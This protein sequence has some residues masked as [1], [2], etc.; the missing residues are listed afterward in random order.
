MKKLFL[1]S[2]SAMAFAATPALAQ[3]APAAP[4]SPSAVPGIP[5]CAEADNNCSVINQDGTNLTATV[6]QSGDGNV[7]DIDQNQGS[8]GA[9]A[10]VTQTGEDASSY[11]LQSNAGI[12]N[13]P[14]KAVVRQSGVGSESAILQTDTRNHSALVTQVGDSSSFIAQNGGLDT[15]AEVLQNG[16]SQNTA[17][18]F[19]EAGNKASVGDS[20]PGNTNSGI[21]QTGSSNNSE[22]YQGNFASATPTGATGVKASNTQIGSDNDSM[23]IQ[24]VTNPAAGG[25]SA[26]LVT[27]DQTGDGNVSSVVQ[28]GIRD[29]QIVK[30]LQSGNDNLSRVEQS[31]PSDSAAGNLANVQQYGDQNDSLVDQSSYTGT[32]NVTQ[33]TVGGINATSPR[34]RFG[35]TVRSNFSRV[36]QSN[37][38]ETVATLTQDGQ[39]N[40]SDISQSNA[41]GMAEATVD[42]DGIFNNSD[43]VQTAAAT[44]NVTQAGD[45]GDNDSMVDQSAD[46]AMATVTQ[47]GDSTAPTYFP[48]NQSSIT[49]AS[50]ATAD[51]EQTGQ[52]NLSDIMQD[53]GAAGALATVRQTNPNASAG[54]GDINSS[55]IT[56]SSLT[57]AFVKQIG[58]GNDS[59]VNQSGTNT[60]L[61][62]N[63]V[64]A[65]EISQLGNDGYSRVGQSGTGNEA[66]LTQLAGSSE[67]HSE[68]DQSGSD[69]FATVM[70]GGF[71]NASYITQSGEGNLATV[72]QTAAGNVSTI[73][74]AGMNNTATVTQSGSNTPM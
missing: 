69:N 12:A 21:I 56:Q 44:A 65:V 59:I 22:I 26:Q 23:I 38:G 6:S 8:T 64:A 71:D 54:A 48:S 45:Y 34:D 4:A 42:Q 49:Q 47:N 13:Y 37:T 36:T 3:S 18:V 29:A 53:A 52:Q 35:D 28:T 15:S 19:Q 63:T 1:A 30:V 11:I 62:T 20:N 9:K 67:A 7:S 27:V 70:Q 16:G 40:R 43:I 58:E 41:S 31:D 24:N 73:T 51:V 17:M 68:I 66:S 50:A 72:S 14:T 25:T 74:Q 46:G 39:L 61:A 10:T 33:T 55:M 32:V 2:V 60:V 57:S 5:E